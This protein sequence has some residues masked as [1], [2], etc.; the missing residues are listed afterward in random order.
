MM[1]FRSLAEIAARR[2]VSRE[3]LSRRLRE[4]WHEVPPPPVITSWDDV[5]V[6]D[7]RGVGDGVVCLL[8]TVERPAVTWHFAPTENTE[9]W[10]TAF[11]LVRGEPRVLVSDQQKGLRLA[12]KRRFPDVPHQRCIAHIVRRAHSWIT[13]RPKTCAGRMARVLVLHLSRVNTEDE[14]RVWT[15]LFERWWLH[16][17][18]FLNEKTEGPNGRHWY[19]HRYLRKAAALLRGALPEMFTFTVTPQTPRTSNHVEG[20]LNAQLAERL[21][22]QRGLPPERQRALV[23]FFLT[24]W[25][26]RHSCTRNIT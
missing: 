12:A 13:K 8:R 3:H 24:D 14:A 1:G 4:A 19:T 16:F 10:H 5:L 23:A 25:N 21:Q 26:K 9:G 11:R 20:G 6:L 18:E 2:A 15:A 17:K 22:R 7:A